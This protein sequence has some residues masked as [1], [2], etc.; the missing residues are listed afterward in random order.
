MNESRSFSDVF[1][2][3][4]GAGDHAAARN[5]PRRLARRADFRL[6]AATVRPSVRTVDGPAGSAAAEPRVMQV[7]LALADA[8]GA[9]LTRDDLI[10]TCWNGQVV[11]D[12]AIH[13]AIAEVRRIARATEAGF[14]VETIPR[15]GY[16]LT[17]LTTAGA[18]GSSHAT[19]LPI[20]APQPAHLSSRRWVLAG[21]LAAAAGAG[22]I[23][24]FASRAPAPDPAARLVEESR[25]AMREGTPAAERRAIALLE[26]AV[27]VSPGS[28]AA[29]GLLALTLARAEEHSHQTTSPAAAVDRAAR[30]A[31]QLDRSN[32]DAQA[33]L[34][35]AIPYYGDWLAAE[36]RFDAVLARHPE[37]VST[38]D[39]RAFL[40]AA[41]GR[42][43]ESAT[44]RLA[45]TREA[46]FDAGLQFRHIYALW[47]LGRVAEADRVASRGME[48]W[49]RHPGIWFG[50][51]WLLTGTG[52]FDRAMAQI[53]DRAMRPQLPPPMVAML[54]SGIGAAIS[55]DRQDVD[56]AVRLVMGQVS[57]SVAAVVNAMML[58][59]LMGAIDEAFELAR[60]YY[61]EQGPIVAATGPQPGQLVVPDQRRRKTN[62]LFTPT[63][64][65][66]QRDRRFLPLMEEMGLT[67]YWQRRGVQPDFM[68]APAV[69]R[70]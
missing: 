56:A 15:V 26:R 62:M 11:G 63:A 44:E 2:L 35:I 24:I 33:A 28:A 59:N 21:G 20:S 1:P 50:R 41:V 55:R 46:S 38:R 29:W 53:N 23:G 34:A 70:S 3:G 66:M 18:S 45:F 42:M 64:A 13:R 60:A 68:A 5:D 30:R 67:D 22:G 16:R 61:L 43:R 25:V 52:R 6:G 4:R 47:F 65:A 36:R 58:L 7:L 8:A 9:V 51:L 40:L 14:T 48:M 39:S 32:A 10:R 69:V 19:D 17:E 12:D 31:L 37:H 57:R 27:A 49:P 54:Q